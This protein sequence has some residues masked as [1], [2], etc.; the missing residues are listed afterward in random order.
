MAE[1]RGNQAGR[2]T[3]ERRLLA[4]EASQLANPLD[5]YTRHRLDIDTAIAAAR[6]KP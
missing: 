4:V 1:A 2:A 3:F 6:R 5:E